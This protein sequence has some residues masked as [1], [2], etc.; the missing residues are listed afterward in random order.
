[1]KLRDKDGDIL[2]SFETALDQYCENH[3]CASCEI[4]KA[5]KGNKCRTWAKTHELL[6]TAL[7]GYDLVWERAGDC[8]PQGVMRVQLDDGA[9]SP[10]RAHDD[11]AGLDIRAREDATV[12]GHG[13]AVFDTGVHIELPKGTAGVL[14]SKSGLNVNHDITSSGVID[15]GY[16]GSIKVK[17][18]NHGDKPY[19]VR[20]GDKISQLVVVKIEQ[21]MAVVVDKISGGERGKNG[22]GSTGRN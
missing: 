6:A 3:I 2:Y 17:L 13:S 10:T 12:P 18:Y 19:Q 4:D 11:D 21:P 20:R 5:A 9:F 7:M 15:V 1:M 16:T 14:K 22:F 8:I